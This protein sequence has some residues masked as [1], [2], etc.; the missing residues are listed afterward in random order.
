MNQDAMKN[1]VAASEL[2]VELKDVLDKSDRVRLVSLCAIGNLI[3]YVIQ[4]DDE[5]VVKYG[6]Q[7]VFDTVIGAL[8]HN[9][10]GVDP[11]AGDG[12]DDGFP[13]PVGEA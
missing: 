7:N 12:A 2:F 1:A 3:A 13:E 11:F 8:A 10:S 4:T 5:D 9:Y 6:L